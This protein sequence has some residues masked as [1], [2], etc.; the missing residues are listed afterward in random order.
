MEENIELYDKMLI[1]QVKF[2][3][4][5][6]A[7]M[8]CLRL[9]NCDLFSAQKH[10]DYLIQRDN[11]SDI[12]I[13]TVFSRNLKAYEAEK[14]KRDNNVGFGQYIIGCLAII[15]LLGLMFFLLFAIY[16]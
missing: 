2:I 16:F 15:V 14:I 10:I 3:G 8:D 12:P 1:S 9:Y 5:W 4:E 13:E 7:I 6:G 11:K